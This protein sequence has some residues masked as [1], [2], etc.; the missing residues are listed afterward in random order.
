[1]NELANLPVSPLSNPDIPIDTVGSGNGGP[2]GESR[3][4]TGGGSLNSTLSAGEAGIGNQDL[5]K[6]IKEVQK[7]ILPQITEDN[8]KT[9]LSV[10]QH[11]KMADQITDVIFQNLMGEMSLQLLDL[12]K[13]P[14]V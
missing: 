13:D 8:N 5:I 1:M 7:D 11:E 12:S 2:L 4:I 6:V 14:V 3:I 9:A 10:E